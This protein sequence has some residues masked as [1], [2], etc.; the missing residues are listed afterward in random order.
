MRSRA[1]S[2]GRAFG[3]RGSKVTTRRWL[4]V[5]VAGLALLLIAGRMAAGVYSE[6][7]WYAAM[8]AL[9]IY[10]A[11]LLYLT[12]LRGGA[13]LLGFGFAFA[14]LYAVRRSIVSL[15]L[16][17][18]IANIDF[19]EEVPGRSMTALVVIV[20]LVLAVLLAIPQDDWVTSALAWTGLPFGE[21]DPY[22]DRDF[23][24]YVY[25]VPFERSLNLWAMVALLVVSAL[26][27]LLYAIT[28]SLRWERG[29]LHVSTYVRRHFAVLGALIL[30]MVGWS[31]RLESVSLLTGGSGE[32]GAF[33][34]FDDKILV[35][36]LTGL[37][38]AA[39][40]SSLVVLWAA[41]HGL[42]QM[43]FAIF[44]L[45]AFGGPIARLVLPWLDRSATADAD[46]L[47]RERPYRSTRTHF[48]RRAFGMDQIVDADSTAVPPMTRQE[49][50]RGVSN[51]DAAA[52]LRSAEQA[53]RD[54]T[55]LASS[56]A[57]APEGLVAIVVQRPS[58]G[59]GAATIT[60]LGAASAD[61][62]GRA[63]SGPSSSADANDTIPPI[64]VAPGASAYAVVAD[65]TGSLPAPSF[66]SWWERLAHAWRLQNLR[67][68][69]Q[70]TPEPRPRIFLHR[71]VRERIT[72][73]VP[74]FTIGPT[75]QATVVGDSLYWMAELFVTSDEYPLAQALRFAGEDRQYVHHAATAVVEGHSGRVFV[76][77]DPAPDPVTRTWLRRFPWLFVSRDRLPSTLRTL[78][79]PPVDRAAVQS[80]AIAHAG[81]PG[82]SVNPNRVASTR[83]PVFDA[84]E[85]EPSL[86]A[87]H[88]DAGPLAATISVLESDE[89]IVGILVARGGAE[90]RV[91]WHRVS[92]RTP[93]RGVLDELWTTARKAGLYG[94]RRGPER[95][96]QIQ[97]LPLKGGVA[98]AESFYSWPADAAPTL[99]GVVL[100]EGQQT[101]TGVTLAEALGISRPIP[102]GA[103]AA[104]RG[105][106]AGL[107]DVMSAAMR[108]GDWK[109]FG[110]AYAALGRLLRSAP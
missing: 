54:L 66:S 24:F 105:R 78:W 38:I 67:L 25:N 42:R 108:R 71:D 30:L 75:L 79:P 1:G 90:P 50:A 60:K 44:V 15:V 53:H 96:G 95:K 84:R 82:D 12:I 13:A 34:A 72:A 56:W 26:V 74:F 81:F 61:E 92:S 62:Q 7:T 9:P 94:S 109:A 104:F 65:S 102:T 93:W 33:T 110:D 98:F 51:W 99:R 89:R 49:A 70:D 11:K 17:R 77:A 18:R 52:V 41:W 69:A 10:Q 73:L 32:F 27:V 31:Y 106:V 40:A 68:L 23:G 76:V 91:E 83:D 5:T 8:G 103:N 63:F 47:A 20:S 45:V 97:L 16:P 39:L 37:S 6:W 88:G 2:S 29:R 14:N 100:L 19:G 107:Y 4:F 55:T 3:S 80:E 46:R 43:A 28:P 87:L 35:P 58:A 86:Y 101:H 22:Q 85:A 48:T 59:L 21:R 36:L 64:L 57:P